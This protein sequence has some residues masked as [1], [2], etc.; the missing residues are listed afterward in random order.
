M[1]TVEVWKRVLG[2]ESSGIEVSN[3]GRVRRLS[4]RKSGACPKYVFRKPSLDS[5]GRPMICL[6]LHAGRIV[7]RSRLLSRV[8]GECFVPN[9]N[10]QKNRFVFQ[11]NGIKT[12]CRAENLF[13]DGTERKYARHSASRCRNWVILK[14]CGREIGRFLGTPNAA[15]FLGRTKQA[16]FKA[17]KDSS[18]CCGCTVENAVL[19][20]DEKKRILG[21]PELCLSMVVPKRN[22]RRKS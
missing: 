19:H 12:D 4:K 1:P 8:I 5:R 17:M 9:P 22:Q 21:D 2:C 16:V 15:R 13:W 11:R 6:R 18:K 14:K 20:E 10:P 7:I 3:L